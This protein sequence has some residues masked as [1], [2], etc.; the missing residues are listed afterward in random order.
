M[1]AGV[2]G[3]QSRRSAKLHGAEDAIDKGNG[4]DAASQAGSC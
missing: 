1:L 3:P 4:D 2:V